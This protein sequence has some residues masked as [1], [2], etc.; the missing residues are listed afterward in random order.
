MDLQIAKDLFFPVFGLAFFSF[1]ISLLVFTRRTVAR[2]ERDMEKDGIPRPA[3]WDGVG[4]RVFWYAYS[5]GIDEGHWLRPRNNEFSEFI[6]E[7]RLIVDY[8]I[9]SDR[10]RARIFLI[11]TTVF[12]VT[13]LG[14]WW[15]LD[16]GQPGN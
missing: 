4:A 10:R 11:T 9:P 14:G 8:V 16:L 1:A 7:S 15:F 12:M 6:F 13:M 5:I 3:L 2:I